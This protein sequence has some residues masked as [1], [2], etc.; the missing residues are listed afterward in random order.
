M[1]VK[2]VVK[3]TLATAAA[4]AGLSCPALAA[5]QPYDVALEYV[6]S[7]GKQCLDTGLVLS[8][9]VS[10]SLSF[11]LVS[12]TNWFSKV[13]GGRDAASSRNI[14]C[15]FQYGG[16][17]VDFNNGD[18]LT[19]RASPA[20][21][22]TDPWRRMDILI[23]SAVR[24]VNK[25]SPP[26]HL[27]GNKNLNTAVFHTSATARIF[28]IAGSDETL[29]TWSKAVG[30]LYSLT[31]SAGD[32][33][34]RDYQPGIKA[35]VVGLYDRVTRTFLKP[36]EG[37]PLIP[38]PV[39]VTPMQ[40]VFR[41]EG[42][43]AFRVLPAVHDVDYIESDGVAYLDTGLKLTSSMSVDI[44]L[45][46]PDAVAGLSSGI[47]GSRSSA[48]S[49]NIALSSFGSTITADF[50]DTGSYD[51]YRAQ[52]SSYSSGL[53]Y[54]VHLGAD[55]RV[56][57]EYETGVSQASKT[58]LWSGDFETPTSA[59]V[60]KTGGTTWATPAARVYS[61]VIKDGSEA[62]RD[63]R[64]CSSNGIACLHDRIG[65]G[66][67]CNANPN[68]GVL[69]AGP[70]REVPRDEGLAVDGTTATGQLELTD[71]GQGAGA[72]DIYAVTKQAPDYDYAVAYLESDGANC[73]DT[74]L[75][76]SNDMEVTITYAI[77]DFSNGP[78]GVFG[79]RSD[80][81]TCNVAI[82]YADSSRISCDFVSGGSYETYRVT[83]LPTTLEKV[84]TSILSAQK[85]SLGGYSND[86]LMPVT[87]WC[88]PGTAWIFGT[89]NVDWRYAKARLY[90]L[91]IKQGGRTIRDYQPCVKDD[92]PCLFDRVERTFLYN[93][94]ASG[95]PFKAGERLELS[96]QD[97]IDGGW[98]DG[99]RSGV[100][101]TLVCS[102]N[103]PTSKLF[104]IP[105]LQPGTHYACQFMAVNGAGESRCP[106]VEG[107][108]Y[109]FTTKGE[110]A[111]LALSYG[112]TRSSRLALTVKRAEGTGTTRIHAVYGAAYAGDDEAL[113]EQD[114]VIGSFAAD[115]TEVEVKSPRLVP[116][117]NYLRLYTE[118]GA[119][120][121]TILVPGTGL[122]QKDAFGLLLLLR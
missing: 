64:P 5:E 87:G 28:D 18:C 121:Q 8:N 106:A 94:G 65:G 15:V 9:D 82:S 7:D 68:G 111:T 90:A 79:S 51:N 38:G 88:T 27:G 47:F 113:W 75:V 45:S 110:S 77:T 62:I 17:L 39:V 26:Q 114:E 12:G 25:H 67:L 66:F 20:L 112:L 48:S 84:Y 69:K 73:I 55:S 1:N 72:C 63:Y 43:P 2:R 31:I 10:V 85:R 16:L 4:V 81:N 105:N 11:A 30:R 58:T 83:L 118:D 70:A 22:A 117:V 109:A 57:R 60:F 93:S 74:G 86:E 40:D 120:S 24:H 59:Y 101:T 92:V 108:S 78:A 46:L 96:D 33:P 107:Q 49:K 21:D 36:E 14:S 71:L 97:F 98:R 19:Y 99:A 3:K 56:V 37:N 95:H 35:G 115:E 100:V 50:S 116:G 103:C 41:D 6:E 61:L 32:V 119:W 53:V 34:L 122:R 76:I 89:Q 44:V 54:A 29:K 42:A 52:C 104:T 91:R 23:S 13:F 80:V 102:A